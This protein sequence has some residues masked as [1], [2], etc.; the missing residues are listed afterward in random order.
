MG[1]RHL[2]VVCSQSA[3]RPGEA[4]G[5]VLRVERTED[6]TLIACA[7][8][9]G[10][11]IRANVAAT[12]ALGRLVGLVR[13]GYSLREAF[14]RLVLTMN[15]AREPGLPFAAFTV[16]RFQPSGET[17]IL[18]YE[19]PPP[20][21]AS[22]HTASVMRQLR[23][24]IEGAELGEA[25]CVLEPG[26]AIVLV[27][28]GITQA[29][30]GAGLPMGW[31]AERLALFVRDQKRGGIA[32]E[33]LPEAVH[34]QARRLW[35]SKRGDD[36]TVCL[37]ACRE[38]RVVRVFTGPPANRAQDDA[39]VGEFL[40]GEGAKVV[41]GATTAQIVA[42]RTG[43]PLH[44]RQDSLDTIAPPFYALEG[45]DLVT[46]GAVTLNQ[47]FNILEEDAGR[48]EP[49]SGVTHLARLLKEADRIEFLVGRAPNLAGGDIA[50]RQQGIL[51]RA[52]IVPLLAE[53]LQ[54]AGK[55]VLVRYA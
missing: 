4:C 10:S 19:A 51:P 20:V 16:A 12:M 38:G 25:H 7:D 13:G 47:V 8:G 52:T 24:E 9:L 3:K 32:W 6:Y 41:C 48:Y 17:T 54:A 5:D 39:A 1:Y 46:E 40:S 2:D 22:Y 42:R 31:G 29:G 21:W 23:S 30:L 37:A 43:K 15:A 49:N 45:I 35:G 36:C 26:E 53:R 18:S 28:D 55:L 50:F 34:R 14:K 44:V 33:E 27:S 11:G